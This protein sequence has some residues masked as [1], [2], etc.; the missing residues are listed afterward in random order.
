MNNEQ[1]H[2]ELSEIRDEFDANLSQIRDVMNEIDAK[3]TELDDLHDESERLI[4]RINALT[5][6]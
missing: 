3:F 1:A 6:N 5:G 2:A 4:K